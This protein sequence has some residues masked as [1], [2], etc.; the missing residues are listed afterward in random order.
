VR[1]R[2]LTWIG[3]GLLILAALAWVS[4]GLMLYFGV[5]RPKRGS[6]VPPVPAETP[7]T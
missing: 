3:V 6:P 5:R 7:A 4:G 2:Y 1:V